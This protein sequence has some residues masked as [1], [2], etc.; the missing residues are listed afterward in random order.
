MN[1]NRLQQVKS[2]ILE[3]NYDWKMVNEWLK[4]KVG[5]VYINK[6]YATPQVKEGTILIFWIWYE[7]ISEEE[8]K[9]KREML[10]L[11]KMDAQKKVN[12]Y[13]STHGTS[14]PSVL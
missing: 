6:M 12:D 13:I 9:D 7:E 14:K 10:D 3:G 2:F 5:K 11:I 8:L 1:P 4:E